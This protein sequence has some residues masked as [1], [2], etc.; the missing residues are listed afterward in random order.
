MFIFVKLYLGLP[1]FYG[2]V[3]SSVVDFMVRTLGPLPSAWMDPRRVTG[4]MISHSITR[5]EGQIHI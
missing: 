1:L 3:P 2:S 5:T 4:K